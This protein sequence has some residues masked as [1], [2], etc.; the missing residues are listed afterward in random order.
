M[1]Q[2]VF[3]PIENEDGEGVTYHRGCPCTP[4]ADSAEIARRGSCPVTARYITRLRRR[5]FDPD[6]TLIERSPSP[7]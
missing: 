7:N 3:R 5:V 4:T 2:P 1:P 6:D